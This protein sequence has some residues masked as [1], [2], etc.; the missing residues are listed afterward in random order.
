MDNW[1]DIP[2]YAGKYQISRCGE[3]RSLSRA[4]SMGRRWAERIL[5]PA[6]VRGGY[7]IVALS[8]NGKAKTRL[9]HRL[10]LETFSGPCP[11]SM[12]ARH[13]DGDASNN[14]LDNLAWG[15]PTENYRDRDRHGT[16]PRGERIGSSKLCE[17]DVWL[18]RACKIT[19]Q[20]AADFF[21]ISRSHISKIR[22]NKYWE[23]VVG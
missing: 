10:L 4:D 21:G 22:T 8:K 16:T 12:E 1:K 7:L 15:T 23:H 5:K 14:R 9:I 17:L 11:D 18:I 6:T 20:Q 3:V 19:Q 13:L 2:G